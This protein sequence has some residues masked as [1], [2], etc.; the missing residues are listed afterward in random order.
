MHACMLAGNPPVVYT[1]AATMAAIHDIW[2]QRA[3]GLKVFFTQ[4]AGA[5][6]KLLFLQQDRQKIRLAFPNVEVIRPFAEV[7][8]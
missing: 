6:L 1:Q 5:N 8:T 2:R 4:D 7:T 3:L